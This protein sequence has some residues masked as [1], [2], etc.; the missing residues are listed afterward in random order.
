MQRYKNK[1]AKWEHFENY[2]FWKGIKL[3]NFCGSKNG[4]ISYSKVGID[5][6]GLYPATHSVATPANN[7]GKFGFEPEQRD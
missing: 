6:S 3:V 7:F 2:S 5:Y 1:F 4:W